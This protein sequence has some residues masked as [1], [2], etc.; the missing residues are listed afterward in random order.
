MGWK[1][2]TVWPVGGGWKREQGVGYECGCVVARV[3]NCLIFW[4]FEGLFGL[5]AGNLRQF[6]SVIGSVASAMAASERTVVA[7]ECPVAAG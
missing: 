7:N 5:W 2:G 6:G 4:G 3:P 1:S